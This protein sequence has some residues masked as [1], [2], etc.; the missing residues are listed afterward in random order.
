MVITTEKVGMKRH[1]LTHSAWAIILAGGDGIRLRDLTSKID[2]DARPKQFSKIFG[3]RSLLAHTRDRLRPIFRDDRSIFVV[4]KDHDKFY[5]EELADVDRARVIEQPANRGTGVAIIAALL[6]LLEYE[7]DAVVGIFPSD[8]YYADNA[9]FGEKVKSAIDIST[10]HDECLVLIGAKPGWPEVEF[11][12]IEP[13]FSIASGSGTPLFGVS[14]FREKPGLSQACELMRNGGL[15]NTFVIIGRTGAFLKVLTATVLPAVSRIAEGIAHGKLDSVYSGMEIIDFSKDVLSVEPRSLL[16]MA[17]G[18][19]GWADL[20]TQARVI[21]ALDRN[22]IEPQWL[23]E[24]R[25]S[26]VTPA[27]LQVQMDHQTLHH[28]I[29]TATA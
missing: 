10:E 25:C 7:T 27:N 12:W 9:A 21:D 1:S 22:N 16:V 24:M 3:E 6:Q 15:W 2:G 26:S 29:A 13:G 5:K 8:H 18:I 19:S 14:R 28:R 4:T 11:G 17:D 20:G 23:R